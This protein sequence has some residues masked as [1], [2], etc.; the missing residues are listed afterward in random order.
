[1]PPHQRT[2]SEYWCGEGA[3][4]PQA[5]ALGEGASIPLSK[6]LASGGTESRTFSSSALSFWLERG[7]GSEISLDE[8]I[9]GLLSGKA[10]AFC[11]SGFLILANRIPTSPV[12][13]FPSLSVGSRSPCYL[14]EWFMSWFW[15]RKSLDVFHNP[16]SVM[17]FPLAVYFQITGILFYWQRPG[18]ELFARKAVGECWWLVALVLSG[19]WYQ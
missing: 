16:C 6:G 11:I 15:K 18:M 12:D 10:N 7:P 1:M 3:L 5:D 4:K 13:R 19:Y 2:P 8:G 17:A 14:S 9:R